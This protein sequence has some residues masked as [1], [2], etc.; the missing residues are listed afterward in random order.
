[1]SKAEEIL[2]L[3]IRDEGL[4]EPEREY[5]FAR[6]IVGGHK[7]IRQRLAD[8]N[9][10]DWRFDFAWPHLMLA[11]EIEGGGWVG[12]RHTTGKGFEADLRK[13]DAAMRYGWTIY[14][15]SPAMVTEGGAISTLRGLIYAKAESCKN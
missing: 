10:K 1:M 13:Y 11:C 2:D 5:R 7:G 12:G 6:D 8:L 3:M 9:L 15:C 14:R 4:P